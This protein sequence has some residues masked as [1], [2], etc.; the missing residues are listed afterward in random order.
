[1]GCDM[2]ATLCRVGR[3]C[4]GLR[5]AFLSGGR[6]PDGRDNRQPTGLYAVPEADAAALANM[7]CRQQLAHGLHR[8]VRH[9]TVTANLD[10]L[11]SGDALNVGNPAV[12]Q[13]HHPLGK[14]G[15]EFRRA[16][17]PGYERLGGLSPEDALPPLD[18]L[19]LTVP[20]E[21]IIARAVTRSWPPE[22]GRCIL[23]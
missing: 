8:L 22:R 2:R 9:H 6:A 1:M 17:G 14:A 23:A 18:G 4:T 5:N 3:L 10:G 13:P 15:V 20:P 11:L 7:L 19:L 21:A 12:G 16:A